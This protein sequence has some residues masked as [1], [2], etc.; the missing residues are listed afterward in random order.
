MTKNKKAIAAALVTHPALSHQESANLICDLFNVSY[1]NRNIMTDKYYA[2]T[3]STAGLPRYTLL[4]ISERL[5]GDNV[6]LNDG[7]DL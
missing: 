4:W 7:D 3:S 2:H 5:Y 1:T 6:V